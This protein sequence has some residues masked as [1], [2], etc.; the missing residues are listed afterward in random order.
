MAKKQAPKKNAGYGIYKEKIEA[1]TDYEKAEDLYEEVQNSSGLTE[2]VKSD[3]QIEL[4]TRVN[5]LKQQAHDD[6]FAN[7][8]KEGARK[9]I[10]PDPELDDEGNPL[11][12]VRKLRAA[13][14]IEAD[15][16]EKQN[17]SEKKIVAP[18]GCE[19]KEISGENLMSIQEQDFKLPADERRLVGARPVKT[20]NRAVPVS[21]YI[22]ILRKLVILA[23]IVIG[24]GSSNAMAAPSS[25]DIAS[26][27]DFTRTKG[28]TVDS[29]GHLQPAADST[30]NIGSSSNQVANVFTDSIVLGAGVLDIGTVQTFTDS[31]ATPDVSN[32][33]YFKTNTTTVTI[34]DFD[35]SGIVD[36]QIIYII[37]KGAITYD[38]TSSGL[39]GGTTD[40]VTASGDLTNWLYDGTDWYLLQF[41]DQS[42]NLA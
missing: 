2:E 30:M 10:S 7:G 12:N 8:D 41:T 20:G 14:E 9:V 25:S 31:D 40:L 19:I 15:E 18:K 38:V 32:G 1:L 37:S 27:T 42:D 34:T 24:F 11:N 29:N 5:K 23:A 33:V 17:S 3:L 39:K 21:R 16:F 26:M 36:G 13:E 22:A 6:K 28:F 4:A 35:G